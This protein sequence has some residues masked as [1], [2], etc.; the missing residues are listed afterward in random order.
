M[1]EYP[2][3]DSIESIDVFETFPFLLSFPFREYDI[4][5]EKGES[6]AEMAGI[7]PVIISESGGIA[8]PEFV[9]FF[10]IGKDTKIALTFY[11]YD[12]NFIH[13]SASKVKK[14]D[15]VREIL[16][17][18]LAS[19]DILEKVDCIK[20]GERFL[21]KIGSSLIAG[22]SFDNTL[23]QFLIAGNHVITKG[24]ITKIKR[25]SK[26]L[27]PSAFRVEIQDVIK[28][29]YNI[30][31]HHIKILLGVVIASKIH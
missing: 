22:R 1:Q 21:K 2:E 6:Y 15:S 5:I 17:T 28:L 18:G 30:H 8:A 14:L 31:L 23:D 27:D 16:D 25:I 29:F 24:D 20:K 4:S 13:E 26:K 11:T 7:D 12:I 10:H 3:D 19:N 9:N